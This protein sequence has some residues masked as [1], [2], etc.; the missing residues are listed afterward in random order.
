MKKITYLLSAMCALFI[1]ACS[2]ESNEPIIPTEK[3]VASF[4][5]DYTF[6]SGNMSRSNESVYDDF[7]ENNIKTKVLVA[8]DYEIEF[9]NKDSGTSYKCSGK[10]SN[11][12]KIILPIGVYKVI[13]KSYAGASCSEKASINFE[14]DVEIKEDT[15]KVVLEADY[16]CWLIMFAK[17]NI[18]SIQYYCVNPIC[19][20]K[21]YKEYFYAFCQNENGYPYFLIKRENGSSFEFRIDDDVFKNGKYYFINDD[22]EASTFNIPEM[23]AGN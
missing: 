7:Y 21:T 18:K 9:R 1:Y 11:E 10:W 12:D 17:S 6:E 23:E 16:D 19:E 8:D 15:K 22:D 3:P 4:L 20:L 13:G 2:S 14:K 5:L